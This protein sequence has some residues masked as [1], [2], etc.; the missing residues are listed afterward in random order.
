MS[1]SRKTPTLSSDERLPVVGLGASAGGLDAFRQFFTN[2]PPDPGAAFVLIQHLDRMQP[3]LL[4]EALSKSTAM[5]V[6]QVVNGT[7]PKA[8]HVYVIPPDADIALLHGALLLVPRTSEDR[9]PHLP[10]DFFFRSL[11]ME[12]GVGA[13]GVVFSGTGADGTEGL[14]AIRGEHGFT[15]AQDPSTARFAGMPRSAIDAGVVDATLTIPAL[16]AELARLVHHPYIVTGSRTAPPSSAPE[17]LRKIMLVV[18]NVVGVDFSEYKTATFERR[19]A[20]RL[21]LHRLET[22]D[23]YL[24]F[25]NGNAEEARA[26]YEDVLIHV[27]SFFR[28]PEVFVSLR[29]KVFK[30]ILAKKRPGE[31]VRIWVAGCSTGEEVYTLAITLMEAI[32]DNGHEFPVQIF[33]SDISGKAIDFARAGLYP[34]SAFTAVGEERL[35]RWF[36]KADH[37]YRV[38]TT[39]REKCVFVRHDLARDPPFSKLDLV[40]CRHVL[41][42]LG[43]ELQKRVL[44]TFHY[45]LN[46]PGYMT[47][48]RSESVAGLDEFFAVYDKKSKIFA[49]KPRTSAA[50]LALPMVGSHPRS[51]TSG[52]SPAGL[53]MSAAEETRQIDREILMH[54]APAGV[55][56]NAK[57]EV[58]EFRGRTSRFLEAPPGKP[59]RNVLKMAKEGVLAPLRTALAQAIREKL[60]ARRQGMAMGGNTAA[61]PCDVVVVPV[62]GL[63]DGSPALFVVLFEEGPAAPRLEGRTPAS[64]RRTAAEEPRQ[65]ANLEKELAA[66]RK[67]L[68]ALAE[69]HGR[70]NEDLMSAN[71]ELVSGN[72]ELQSLNEELETAKEEL[73]S[74]NEELTTV[75]DELQSRNQELGVINSDL[76][77]LLNAVDLPI[78]ILDSGRRIRRYTP[79]ALDVM[80]L[81]PSDLGRPIEDIRPVVNVTDLDK[82]I[83]EAIDRLEVRQSEVQDRDGHWFRMQI[84]PY[85][86]ADNKIDGAIVSFV[87]I[88]LL[89]HHLRAAEDA[90]DYA[91]AIVEAVGIPLLVLDPALRIVSANGAYYRSFKAVSPAVENRFLHEID[92]GCWDI[93]ELR[94]ALTRM[95]PSGGPLAVLEVERAF[96]QV[97]RRTISISARVVDS[98]PVPM[99]VLAL[100]DVTDRRSAEA[101][102]AGLLLAT[103]EA[104][105]GAERANRAKD[106]FLATLSHELRT[107]L[108]S[109]LMH[110]QLLARNS[111]DPARIARS[112]EVIE[113]SA[114]T[115]ALLIEDLLDV[116][117]ITAGKLQMDSKPVDMAGVVRGALEM[118]T[119]AADAKRINFL[120]TA[121]DSPVYVMGD[122]TRL[123]QAVSNLLT[124]AVKFSPPDSEISILVE[125]LAGITRI[126]VIDS[127]SGI[128]ADF[129]PEVFRRFSQQT[130]SNARVHGGLGLG[131]AIV[132]HIVE[133]HGGS[134]MAASPGRGRG[135]TFSIVLPMTE[136]PEKDGLREA[137]AT[138]Q[139]LVSAGD[140]HQLDQLRVLVVEDDLTLREVVARSLELA[141]ASVGVAGSAR[142]AYTLLSSF[143]PDVVVSDIAMPGEDGYSL[144]ERIRA[145]PDASIRRVPALALTALAS[146]EDRQRALSAGFQEFLAKPPD[147]ARLTASVAQLARG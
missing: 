69:E 138:A 147:I 87:D 100:E 86:N 29:K 67:Y 97:G 102:R 103:E 5:P 79:K 94:T 66:T 42:Y 134:V 105:R 23:D 51:S 101:Q 39:L 139:R 18:R 115:Q 127:G 50:Y 109:I 44:L 24:K 99:I 75:N 82:Q 135:A 78:L 40:S 8:N 9:K 113:R 118:V 19:L 27:T 96:S 31:A 37:G 116:S 38:N 98:Q 43:A 136:I 63:P 59:Q 55:I 28:D 81:L 52:T 123:Q 143:H 129:L 77:N 90:R 22:L 15:L 6:V 124:N 137:L 47:L 17:T 60:P 35:Q 72:E 83:A 117:R 26:L 122:A 36:R 142:E 57:M 13:I 7:L 61:K 114:R 80:H 110:A 120:V 121:P 73:Q 91:A 46:Q 130:T 14:R 146:T 128:D 104:R 106:D 125:R 93:P 126:Q 108:S 95:L 41:I 16:A 34:E 92:N 49:R 107:P 70:T 4:A 131:L 119:P 54:Y 68:Q 20:R 140:I 58:L 25:L 145:H 32:A 45:C 71:E 1:R 12:R 132:R 64:R 133:A 112:G 48:G 33:G 141:G 10:I 65:V 144:M 84:R 3:S 85:K 74:S 89:K 111:S 62:T 53:P 11:A 56:V 30:E 21:A 76:L 88:D 2:L